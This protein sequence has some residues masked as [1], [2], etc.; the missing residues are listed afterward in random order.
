MIT[1]ACEASPLRS[2]SRAVADDAAVS[3]IRQTREAEVEDLHPI[4]RRD[5]HVGRLEVAMDDP[6]FVR[7]LER[8]GNLVGDGERLVDRHRPAHETFRERL[9]LDQFH[10]EHMPTDRFLEAVSAAMCG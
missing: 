9:A 7:G 2:E 6:L 10:D 4:L 1:P 5:L 3:V 8:F